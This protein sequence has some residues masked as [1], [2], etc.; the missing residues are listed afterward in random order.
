M[1]SSQTTLTQACAERA[2]YTVMQ[3]V[4]VLQSDGKLLQAFHG[5]ADAVKDCAHSGKTSI[6]VSSLKLLKSCILIYS[7][8][9][10]GGLGM[11]AKEVCLSTN[12]LKPLPVP[13]DPELYISLPAQ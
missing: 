9:V 12:P 3:D 6:R 5:A 1:H 2:L 10:Q 13:I 4:K 7:S 8:T 11:P